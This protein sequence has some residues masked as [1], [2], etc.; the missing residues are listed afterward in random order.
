MSTT[1]TITLITTAIVLP[2]LAIYFTEEGVDDTFIWLV[3]ICIVGS[4]VAA[5]VLFWPSPWLGLLLAYEIFIAIGLEG[6]F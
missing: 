6:I 1:I 5:W 2:L 4:H 3:I